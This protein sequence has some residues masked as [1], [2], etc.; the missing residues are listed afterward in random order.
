MNEPRVEHDALEFYYY[1][2]YAALR[3]FRAFAVVGWLVALLG[4]AAFFFAW[5]LVRPW[6]WFSLLLCCANVVSGIAVVQI[7]VGALDAYVRIPCSYDGSRENG[8]AGVV[9]ELRSIMKEVEE[10]GWREAQVA[11]RGLLL[12]G[13]RFGLPHPDRPGIP[14][15]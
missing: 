7:A 5:D 11:I 8:A 4:F 12:V 13:E 9:E 14:R 10:G 1:G 6:G 3:R 15:K 2:F